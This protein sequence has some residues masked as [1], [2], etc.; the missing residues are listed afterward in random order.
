M[1]HDNALVI[2]PLGFALGCTRVGLLV[3]LLVVLGLVGFLVSLFKG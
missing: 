3:W 1:V 2:G